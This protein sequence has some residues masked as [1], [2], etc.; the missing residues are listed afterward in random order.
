MS[1]GEADQLDHRITVQ[2]LVRK[3]GYRTAIF[4]KFLNAWPVEVNPPFF[5]DWAIS[6]GNYT[7]SFWNIEGRPRQKRS[8]SVDFVAKQA[9][10]F[11]RDADRS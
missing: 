11:I 2:R 6:N 10:R 1:H 7:K 9:V 4:G 3:K 8:Y 5:D